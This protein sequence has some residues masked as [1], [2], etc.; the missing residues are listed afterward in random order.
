MDCGHSLP[1]ERNPDTIPGSARTTPAVLLP[2]AYTSSADR[3]NPPPNLPAD[4][5]PAEAAADDTAGYASAAN[6]QHS[7]PRHWQNQ[8]ATDLPLNGK[9]SDPWDNCAEN[10]GPA[11]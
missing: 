2:S 5:T 7:H 9:T 4:N 10:T 6:A 11:R 3:Q 1:P 8:S